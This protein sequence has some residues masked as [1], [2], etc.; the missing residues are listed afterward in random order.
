MG[1]FGKG[2]GELII[3]LLVVCCITVPLGLW[4]LVDI[5]IWTSHHVSFSVH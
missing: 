5:A 3:F 4:K 2:I 1:D